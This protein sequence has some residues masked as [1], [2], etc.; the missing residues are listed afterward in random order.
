MLEQMHRESDG[1]LLLGRNTVTGEKSSTPDSTALALVIMKSF[2]SSCSRHNLGVNV[3][4]QKV[5]I[6]FEFDQFRF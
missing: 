5:T 4:A 3:I 6:V 1:R 2:R